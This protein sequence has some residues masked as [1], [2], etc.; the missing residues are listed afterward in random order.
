MC[1][2]FAVERA[3]LLSRCGRR[4]VGCA[5]DR[6]WEN[7]IWN[8]KDVKELAPLCV[9]LVTGKGGLM[10]SSQKTTVRDVVNQERL[11]VESAKVQAASNDIPIYPSLGIKSMVPDQSAA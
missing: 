9:R 2:N 1:D 3:I 6:N 4:D 11:N 7:A 8:A 5:L 10:A